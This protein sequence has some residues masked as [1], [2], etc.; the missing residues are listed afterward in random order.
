M[1]NEGRKNKPVSFNINDEL[2]LALLK[3][4]E[5]INPLTG[6][7][8]NFSKYVKRLIEKD[9]KQGPNSEIRIDRNDPILHEDEEYTIETKEAMNSFL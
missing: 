5:Q 1:S 3:H 7:P 2:E 9:M 8:Q 4:A 6:K